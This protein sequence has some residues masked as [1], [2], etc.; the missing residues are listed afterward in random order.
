MPHV[1]KLKKLTTFFP[2]DLSLDLHALKQKKT[3]K[4]K[5]K[6]KKNLRFNNQYK[7][8]KTVL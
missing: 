6:K 5:N 2:Q 7:W 3:K 8:E 4:T 1:Q